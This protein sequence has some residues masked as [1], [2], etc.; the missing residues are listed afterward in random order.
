MKRNHRYRRMPKNSNQQHHPMKRY[1]TIP[2]TDALLL[3]LKETP[4][5]FEQEARLLLAIKLFELKRI[6][7]GQAA[8]LAGI[9]RV[10][11]MFELKKHGLSPI[12]IDPAEVASDATNA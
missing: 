2:Y 8:Q 11:F 12:G 6:T 7:T 9:D 3:S 5:R 1:A 10:A 4:E